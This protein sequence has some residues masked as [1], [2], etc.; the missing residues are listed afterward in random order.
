MKTFNAK[1]KTPVENYTGI[2]ACVAFAD[3][4]AEAVIDESQLAYFKNAG[5]KVEAKEIKSEEDTVD[6]KT[7]KKTEKK[8]K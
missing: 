7:K 4:K 3:G 8:G 6:K 2:V 5:Y 1:I